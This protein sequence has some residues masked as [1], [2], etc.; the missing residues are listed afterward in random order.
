MLIAVLSDTHGRQAAV[1]TALRYVRSRGAQLVLH[2]GD[3]DDAATVR[4]FAGI[5]S[6]FVLGNCDTKRDELRRAVAAIAGTCHE[7]FG[8]LELGGQK[9]AFLHGHDHRLHKDVENSDYFDYLFYGHSHRAEE[10]RTG[11]TH[12]VNPGALHRA[13]PKTFVL[14]DLASAALEQVHLDRLNG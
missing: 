12:V 10:H 14:L 11:R 3:I 8:D 1:E 9:I 6:H 13:N 2:C 4:L 7:P 5:T